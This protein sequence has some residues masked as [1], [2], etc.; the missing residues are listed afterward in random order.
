MH[1]SIADILADTAQNAIEAGAQNI[2]VELTEDGTMIRVDIRDDGKGMDEATQRR[3][4]DPFY[5]EPGKHD[6]RKVG[7]GLPILR[8]VAEATGGGVSL[9]SAPGKGTTLSYSFSAGHLDLP[10][11]GDIPG[12]MLGLFNYP[13]DFE[14]TFSHVKGGSGYEISR[15]ELR[16]AVG[17]LED[18]EGLS[19]AREFLRSQEESLAA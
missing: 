17:S 19:L 5:T 3:A 18:V 6:G 13:G 10:P 1:A 15:S 14:L 12:M 9:V 4:F 8:Q 11:M 7:L 2:R 16:D